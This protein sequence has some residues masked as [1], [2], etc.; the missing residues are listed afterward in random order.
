MI[1]PAWEVADVLRLCSDQ[2][3]RNRKLPQSVKRVVLDI[4]KCRTAAL[5]GHKIG[6]FKC[7]YSEISYNSCRNRHCPKCQYSKREQWVLNREADLLPVKYFHLVFTLPHELNRCVMAN[8]E[9][10][11]NILFT[12]AWK[13]INNLS[14]DPRWIGAKAGMISV[15]HTW[16]QN[17]SFHPHVHCL[18]PNGAWETHLRKWVYPK[19][20]RFLFP[21][22]VMSK[23][24]RGI[25]LSLLT[26][27][28]QEDRLKWSADSWKQLHS[29]IR[30]AGFLVFAKIPFA[31]PQQVLHYLGRYSHRVAIANHRILKVNSQ[32]VAF[33]YK[34]YRDGKIKVLTLTPDQFARRFLMHILPKGF[35]KFRYYGIYANRGKNKRIT[36]ILQ[37]FERRRKLPR[38]FSPVQSLKVLDIHL[39]RCPRCK[40]GKM[41][42]L[43]LIAPIRGDPFPNSSFTPA[44]LYAHC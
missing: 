43:F 20:K 23:M 6:C 39:D 17:L 9:V 37:F 1:R 27:A 7:G 41:V 33:R 21:V 3:L 10:A 22:R 8:P 14:N 44:N 12:A 38:V 4:I 18:V 35:A 15:L 16:G 28:Y 25:F 42:P 36:E 32:S 5:G 30:N 26:K 40:S 11:Y 31:G 2:I 24:Y 34:D 29:Q 13:T 19:N